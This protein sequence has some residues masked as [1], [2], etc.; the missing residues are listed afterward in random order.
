MPGVSEDEFLIS[1]SQLQ[2]ALPGVGFC[3]SALS[4]KLDDLCRFT[5]ND[6]HGT[7]RTF[8]TQLLWGRNSSYL[9][10]VPVPDETVPY[11]RDFTAAAAPA[12]PTRTVTPIIAHKIFFH[13]NKKSLKRLQDNSAGLRIVGD[14]N[15]LD[16]P[17]DEA[18]LA[19]KMKKTGSTT[20]ER[21]IT[22]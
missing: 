18:C 16:D 14:I 11:L 12:R 19:G 3:R 13:L 8:Y 22:L 15:K 1:Y 2:H 9:R 17:P 6:V 7:E 21:V 5:V 4:N 10:T 20:P